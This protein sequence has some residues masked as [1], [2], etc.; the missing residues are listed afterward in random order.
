MNAA[1]QIQ[2]KELQSAITLIQRL[3]LPSYY[4][5]I[6]YPVV[7]NGY[8]HMSFPINY[9]RNIAIRNV[10][11]SHFLVIDADMR[12]S[13]WFTVLLVIISEYVIRVILD[14]FFFKER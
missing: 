7:D 4:T 10:H 1:I 8:S 9:L 14:A 5:V 2:K 11:T 13:G 12:P 6:L 3:D